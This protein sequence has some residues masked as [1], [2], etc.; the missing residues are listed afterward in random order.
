MLIVTLPCSAWWN[1]PHQTIALIA[2][3]HLT[4]KSKTQVDRLVRAFEWYEGITLSGI[5]NISNDDAAF[6]QTNKYQQESKQPHLLQLK[7]QK[8][9]LFMA[10]WPDELNHVGIAQ[11]RAWHGVNHYYSTNKRWLPKATPFNEVEDGIFAIHYLKNI[12]RSRAP[13]RERAYA[14][15]FLIHI[16]GDLHQPLHAVNIFSQDWPEGNHWGHDVR[17]NSPNKH[18]Q[19]LSDLHS[20]WDSVLGSMITVTPTRAQL[21]YNVNYLEQNYSNKIFTEASRDLDPSHWAENSF[22]LAMRYAYTQDI[23]RY[24]KAFA[25]PNNGD[26]LQAHRNKHTTM[27]QLEKRNICQFGVNQTPSKR[28][29]LENKIRA[30]KQLLLAA[31]RLAYLLNEIYQRC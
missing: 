30:E 5:L 15:S 22:N 14:L 3:R 20:L 2:Y 31:Y 16:V 7:R 6:T 27:S 8:T 13:E 4:P 17:I 10:I 24:N 12:L 28:Y 21:R 18:K 29:L 23:S 11:F 1:E 25:Q 19:R 9:Y 26:D